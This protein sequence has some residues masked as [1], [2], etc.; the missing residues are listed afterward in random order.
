M[1]CAAPPGA[2]NCLPASP[3]HFAPYQNLECCQGGGYCSQGAC[4]P[5][6]FKCSGG[7][8]DI[9]GVGQCCSQVQGSDKS[10]SF[11][12]RW[13]F[14]GDEAQ[15]CPDGRECCSSAGCCDDGEYCKLGHCISAQ[16]ACDTCSAAWTA[17]F[18]KLEDSLPSVCDVQKPF[19]I[20]TCETMCFTRGAE[21]DPCEPEFCDSFVEFWYESC[22][23]AQGDPPTWD[24]VQEGALHAA[25]PACAGS[26]VASPGVPAI[27]HNLTGD[28]SASLIES[29]F[30]TQEQVSGG[31]AATGAVFSDASGNR[32]RRDYLFP[33]CNVTVVSK[34]LSGSPD[35]KWLLFSGSNCTGHNNGDCTKLV[36]QPHANSTLAPYWS[37]VDGAKL[38]G[39]QPQYD[40]VLWSSA[41]FN[42]SVCVSNSTGHSLP[43]FVSPGTFSVRPSSSNSTW[44]GKTAFTNVIVGR[45][46]PT[47]F[48]IPQ[49]CL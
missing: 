31:A 29:G 21:G 7:T 45:P 18:D 34:W 26:K 10:T 28:F 2:Y 30:A 27:A 39:A 22:K 9:Y 5:A 17:M 1:C 8:T 24:D 38:V 23:T 3:P 42:A 11:T 35:H 47:L 32:T 19:F 48:V 12:G 49:K 46:D 33:G 25:C 36:G 14:H 4:C 20:D 15:C 44:Q 37:W 43:V 13:C 16:L 41:R 6:G 40:C